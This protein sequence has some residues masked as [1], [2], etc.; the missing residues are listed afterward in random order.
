[1]SQAGKK[2]RNPGYVPGDPWVICDLCGFA[3]RQSEMKETWDGNIVCEQDFETRHPQ[4]FVKGLGD[5]TSIDGLEN[6]EPTDEFNEV[7]YVAD[8][9]N[10]TIPDGNFDSNNGSL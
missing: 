4:D 8:D 3:Y 1:M 6:P 2:T 5:D 10:D 7:N 9:A